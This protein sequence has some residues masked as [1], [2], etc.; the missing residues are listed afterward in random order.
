MRSSK[1]EPIVEE[2]ELLEANPSYAHVRFQDGREDTVS[3]RHL[4]PSGFVGRP[5]THPGVSNC[6]DPVPILVGVPPPGQTEN[7]PEGNVPTSTRD[8]IPEN[9][10]PDLN[11][12]DSILN[13]NSCPDVP[14]PGSLQHL[15]TSS[16]IKK[17]PAYLKD[18]VLY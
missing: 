5:E 8:N 3:V 7:D 17:P 1:Y 15:R 16:R 10:H 6:E 12:S 14:D 11:V 18:Y 4:A 2:V 9:D 13:K